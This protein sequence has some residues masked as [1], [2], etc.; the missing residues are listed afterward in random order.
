MD[1]PIVQTSQDRDAALR[2][3]FWPAKI[4]RGD[5]ICRF[6]LSVLLTGR[7]CCVLDTP[8]CICLRAPTVALA[9]ENRFSASSVPAPCRSLASVE[10]SLIL[11]CCRLREWMC[12]ARC[13]RASLHAA[14]S[15]FSWRFLSRLDTHEFPSELPERISA[16]CLIGRREVQLRWRLLP[17]KRLPAGVD[18]DSI[19]AS[20]SWSQPPPA[21]REFRLF[22]LLPRLTLLDCS[23]RLYLSSQCWDRLFALSSFDQ[24]R[25][26]IVADLVR[27]NGVER[28]EAVCR[29]RLE[30]MER[31]QQRDL[32]PQLLT[33][34]FRRADSSSALLLTRPQA[35]A[36]W[37]MR[38]TRNREADIFHTLLSPLLHSVHRL[39]LCC[40]V[41]DPYGL[42][43]DP[44]A[45]PVNVGRIAGV[46]DLRLESTWQ[47]GDIHFDIAA[48]FEQAAEDCDT[49]IT[50]VKIQA[51]SGL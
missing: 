1:P 5:S 9:M 8:V 27:T 44:R 32:L 10:W 25:T 13:C 2:Q 35:D 28:P 41:D 33:A 20:M 17:S 4:T 15:D 49:I 16:S 3:R 7:P 46:R 37:E 18:P 51:D 30:I 22:S 31:L 34:D 14:S 42:C 36:R 26:L 24:L 6:A 39:I 50:A 48:Y 19:R 45:W 11:Q 38:L 43:A 21:N 47:P 40:T 12:L 23:H 29:Q